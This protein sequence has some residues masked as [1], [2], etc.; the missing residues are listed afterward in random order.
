MSAKITHISYQF[1]VASMRL[2][3]EE[4][5]VEAT[6]GN[7][8]EAV[9]AALQREYPGADVEVEG[10]YGT[11]GMPTQITME[12]D[13]GEVYDQR[14]EDSIREIGQRV[15]DRQEFEWVEK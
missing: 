5:N 11:D 10:T 3:E 8:E 1:E 13:D 9:K 7:F 12:L 14:T 4:D 2:D 15:W 6:V